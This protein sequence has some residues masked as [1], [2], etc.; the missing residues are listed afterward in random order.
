MIFFY[1]LNFDFYLEVMKKKKNFFWRILL[2]NNKNKN[3][4][5]S[6]KC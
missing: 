2:F 5:K 3:T 4:K 1:I 6:D